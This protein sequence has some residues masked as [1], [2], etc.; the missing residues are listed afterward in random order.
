[1]TTDAPALF[2]HETPKPQ[3]CEHQWTEL[4]GDGF[5]GNCV[6][7]GMSFARHVFTECP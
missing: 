4:E 1:M 3:G 6:K 7:C 2:Y 5:G